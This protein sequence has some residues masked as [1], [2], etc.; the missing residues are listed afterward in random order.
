[1]TPHIAA[2]SRD[3]SGIL[4]QSIAHGQVY[5]AT[6]NS[7]SMA[8]NAPTTEGQIWYTFR[9]LCD[10]GQCLACHSSVIN[11]DMWSRDTSLEP[12][13]R[14]EENAVN[15]TRL[16]LSRPEISGF[17]ICI[18]GLMSGHFVKILS[19]EALLYKGL[20]ICG[21]IYRVRM[22]VAA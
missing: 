8:E 7:W 18:F 2:I 20:Q 11:T 10:F 16:A 19:P 17:Q 22:V 15:R 1:M 13:R 5:K 3:D 14:A 9:N 12:P 6:K 4:K 21:L